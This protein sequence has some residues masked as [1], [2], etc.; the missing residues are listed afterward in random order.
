MPAPH[1]AAPRRTGSF[2]RDDTPC[3]TK[4]A[5]RRRRMRKIRG[6]K[7][8]RERKSVV[9]RRTELDDD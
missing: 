7:R 1:R 3:S 4:G 2:A 8:E 5:G 6:K 9:R